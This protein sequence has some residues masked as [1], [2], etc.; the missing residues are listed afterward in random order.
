MD[1]PGL[2]L[3]HYLV[4][5]WKLHDF[6]LQ[7]SHS[8]HQQMFGWHQSSYVK[9]IIIAHVNARKTGSEISRTVTRKWEGLSLVDVGI[10]P[11]LYNQSAFSLV[12]KHW[13]W[14]PISLHHVRLGAN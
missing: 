4:A 14:L 10:S 1:V 6:E 11:F 12:I 8:V 7:W 13:S 2:E 5:Q 9:S 3:G